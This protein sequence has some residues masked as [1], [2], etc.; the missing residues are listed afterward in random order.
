MTVLAKQY[1][2][3]DLRMLVVPSGGSGAGGRLAPVL[4]LW[5]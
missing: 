1:V 5:N 4:V 3:S 2:E